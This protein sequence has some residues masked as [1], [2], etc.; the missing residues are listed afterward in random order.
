MRAWTSLG[1]MPVLLVVTVVAT[2]IFLWVRDRRAALMMAISGAGAGLLNEA[3]KAAFARARPAAALRLTG[4]SGFAF[5]SGH[6][7]GSAAVYG[8]L[9]LLLARDW[10]SRRAVIFGGLGAVVL[11]IG[12]SRAYLFV[13]YPTDVLAGWALGLAWTLALRRWLRTHESPA[14]RPRFPQQGT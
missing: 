12:L 9:A 8:A 3:L 2:L 4:A 13:H 14:R 6:S 7:M 11:L 10:P 1:A 5:P